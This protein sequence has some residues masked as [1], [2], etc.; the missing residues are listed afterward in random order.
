MP[1]GDLSTRQRWW[2]FLSLPLCGR[3]QGHRPS[4]DLTQ[5]GPSWP[6]TPEM[7]GQP[8][9]RPVPPVRPAAATCRRPSFLGGLAA[10]AARPVLSP[11]RQLISPRALHC[12]RASRTAGKGASSGRKSV[13]QVVRESREPAEPRRMGEAG[14]DQTM[15]SVGSRAT[16]GRSRAEIG[17]VEQRLRVPARPQLLG[18]ER[19]KESQHRLMSSRPWG[20]CGGSGPGSRQGQGKGQSPSQERRKAA[21]VA[22]LH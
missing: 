1:H 13:S 21:I 15:R 2:L 4:S 10:L 19:Y 14:R 20:G 18:S 12:L 22:G 7:S 9:S 6:T 17:R 8:C 5:G 16:L 11:G 3:E